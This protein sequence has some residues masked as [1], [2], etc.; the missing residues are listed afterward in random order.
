MLLE[1]LKIYLDKYLDVRSFSDPSLNG[2]QVE[3]FKECTCVATATTALAN[4]IEAYASVT[5]N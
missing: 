2:L 5:V 4:P 1:D 3:G